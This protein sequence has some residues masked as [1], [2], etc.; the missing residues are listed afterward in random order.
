MRASRV[1]LKVVTVSLALALIATVCAAQTIR[2]QRKFG[3]LEGMTGV[4]TQIGGTRVTVSPEDGRSESVTIHLKDA[5]GLKVGDT[6][7]ME[8]G[9]LVKITAQPDQPAQPV[10]ERVGETSTVKESKEA[11]GVKEPPPTGQPVPAQS[12]Q[13]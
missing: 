11:A 5:S 13:K 9:T 3:L 10:A 4:V 2:S 6:V 12:Q 7:R 8:G 1:C